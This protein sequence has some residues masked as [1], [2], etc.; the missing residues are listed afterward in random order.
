MDD[1]AEDDTSEIWTDAA[2]D[3]KL[4]VSKNTLAVGTLRN[5][6]VSFELEVLVLQQKDFDT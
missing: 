5:V 1:A 2:M 6:D 3:A 4:A